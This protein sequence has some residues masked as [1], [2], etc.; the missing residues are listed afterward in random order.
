MT[1]D[2]FS[3]RVVSSEAELAGRLMELQIA[4]R[5]SCHQPTNARRRA[6]LALAVSFPA[7]RD[8]PTRR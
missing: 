5:S 6:A 8:P 2:K 1:A 3:G 4:D 7:S